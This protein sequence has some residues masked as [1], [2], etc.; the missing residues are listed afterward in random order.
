MEYGFGGT[1]QLQDCCT[2]GLYCSRITV[3]AWLNAAAVQ[4][5]AREMKII[6]LRARI[7]YEF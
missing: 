4:Q 5:K 7:T 6:H 3:P 1:V 2:A